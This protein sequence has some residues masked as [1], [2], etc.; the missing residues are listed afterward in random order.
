[1]SRIGEE[2]AARAQAL[3]GVRFRAQG[4]D[5]AHGLDCAG[6]AAAAAGVAVERVRR[7]YAIR[8]G[9]LAQIEHD[10]CE[11]GCRPVAGVAEPGDV[12]VCEAGPKQFHLVVVTHRAF[13]HADARL[14][15][16]VERPFPTPWPVLGV[17]R[18]GWEEE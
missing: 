12:M 14:R 6:T 4:R 18:A 7:G 1:M 10:L 15:M 3:V 9:S 2:I 11:L 8:G 16:V 5:P 13:V 17:W